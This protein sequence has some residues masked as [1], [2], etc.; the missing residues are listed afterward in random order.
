MSTNLYSKL[1]NCAEWR[2]YKDANTAYCNRSEK[3]FSLGFKNTGFR[4]DSFLD[5]FEGAGTCNRCYFSLGNT[6]TI[7]SNIAYL[8]NSVKQLTDD[9][10]ISIT[11]ES[12]P[13][14]FI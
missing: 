1:N 14:L 9:G 2:I 4:N 8:M 13:E 5:C 11:P 10:Y 12:Y 3:H 7:E 6:C